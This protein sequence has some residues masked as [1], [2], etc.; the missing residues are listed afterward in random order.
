MSRANAVGMAI[1]WSVGL[2]AVLVGVVD[3]PWW[4]I[5]VLAMIAGAYWSFGRTLLFP[6]DS[7]R[8]EALGANGQPLPR[9]QAR[10]DRRARRSGR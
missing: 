8:K 7:A 6:G 10:A 1:S 2:Y 4:G 5:V 3:A 9:S